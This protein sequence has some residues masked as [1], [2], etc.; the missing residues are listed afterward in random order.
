[1]MLLLLLLR[2]LNVSTNAAIL[3]QD[4][5]PAMMLPSAAGAYLVGLVE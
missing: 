3:V 5:N 1:M 4:E 2:I